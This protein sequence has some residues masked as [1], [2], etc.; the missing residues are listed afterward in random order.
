MRAAEI[1]QSCAGEN[2]FCRIEA[3]W[4]GVFFHNR[5][6]YHK[7]KKFFVFR[8]EKIS[9]SANFF[10]EIRNCFAG[11]YGRG[12]GIAFAETRLETH[13]VS[14]FVCDERLPT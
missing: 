1:A 14:F 5:K 4:T 3:F 2:Y 12:S 13:L 7:K 9:I 6:L 8:I 11:R 10:C